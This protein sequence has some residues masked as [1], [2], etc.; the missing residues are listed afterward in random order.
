LEIGLV[1]LRV[2]DFLAKM[3][4]R[5]PV[6]I[7]IEL[8]PARSRWKN[9]FSGVFES[10]LPRS[11]ARHALVHLE[12]LTQQRVPP[13]LEVVSKTFPTGVLKLSVGCRVQRY[14]GQKLEQIPYSLLL[15]F[16]LGLLTHA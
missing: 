8:R 6:K 11:V 16:E 3:E 1:F 12:W 9:L 10:R 4:T 7:R 5:V 2:A 15:M 14:L 13:I